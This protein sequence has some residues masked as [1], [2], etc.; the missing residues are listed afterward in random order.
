MKNV[1]LII[2]FST[3]EVTTLVANNDT[4]RIIQSD[5]SRFE[6]IKYGISVDSLPV[7][8][9]TVK[10]MDF[11][12]DV[13]FFELKDNI[14]QFLYTRR[15]NAAGDTIFIN[16][17]LNALY[18]FEIYREDSYVQFQDYKSS[19][20]QQYHG[21]K[22]YYNKKYRWKFFTMS[23]DGESAWG[24]CYDV[25]DDSLYN[26]NDNR[27]K[28]TIM[29]GLLFFIM[30]TCALWIFFRPLTEIERWKMPLILLIGITV[31]SLCLTL[32]L[33]GYIRNQ[34][35]Y[36]LL[37]FW[38]IYLVEKYLK[39][40]SI[41]I[42]VIF[43]YI[44]CVLVTSFW[45]YMQF[46]QVYDTVKLADGTKV[47]IQWRRGTDLPKRFF[48]KQ[49]IS[50]MVP[51]QVSDHGNH[52]NVYVSKY[53]FREGEWPVVNDEIFSWIS[54]FLHDEP[55]GDLSFREARFV[56]Q[57]LKRIC[58][59]NFDFLTYSEWQSAA[60]KQPHSPHE[61]D[62]C[63]VDEGSPNE[64][65]LF[66]IAGNI[67]EY[68]SDYCGTNRLG[69]SADTLITSYN[70]I[71]VAGYPFI[72]EDS[73][74]FSFMNKNVRTGSVGFRLIYRPN[75]IGARR[76]Y[77][78]GTLRS[79]RAFTKLPKEIKL[80]SIDGHN[81][82]ELDNYESFEDLLIECRFKKYSVQAKDMSTKKI[83]HFNQAKGFEYYD[84]EPVFSFIGMDE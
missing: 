83:F 28:D 72:C 47:E 73:I 71:N 55:K 81:I 45:I 8:K 41:I 57:F 68:T 65:G 15:T 32:F 36:P 48:F 49:M 9:G 29:I 16:D 43:H 75:D 30:V 59:V 82:S 26:L 46:Y 7:Y 27:T 25:G 24:N 22:T 42:K 3:I 2:L 11:S 64:F 5:S 38:L 61:N 70:N 33:D 78:K 13:G 21:S 20:K 39:V 6:G 37:S 53:E 14:L 77:I 19:N 52:Y 80:I 51:V 60:L 4:I 23:T 66:N 50:K 31:L 69:L 63:D 10:H 84:Y 79:D 67:P 40:K 12:R 56:V 34:L 62:Y 76:F 1:I 58:G 18:Q 54:Y 74:S 17:F 44:L 35:A